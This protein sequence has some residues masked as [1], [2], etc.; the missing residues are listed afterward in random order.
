MMA[1][2]TYKVV[3]AH[4]KETRSIVSTTRATMNISSVCNRMRKGQYGSDQMCY[5]YGATVDGPPM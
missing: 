4:C 5:V 3:Q 1:I 2:P